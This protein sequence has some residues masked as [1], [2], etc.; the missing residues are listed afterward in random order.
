[1][2]QISQIFT[3]GQKGFANIAAEF[4]ALSCFFAPIQH[5]FFHFLIFSKL[6]VL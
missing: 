4:I 5:F 1:L 6:Q 2:K 3:S